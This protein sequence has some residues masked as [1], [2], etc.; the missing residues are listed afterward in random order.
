MQRAIRMPRIGWHLLLA[1]MLLVMQQA[2]LRH[3]LQHATQD[4]GHPAHSTLC[5]E[6]LAYAATDTVTPSAPQVIAP[7]AVHGLPP[8]DLRQAQ[9]DPSPQAGYQTRAPPRADAQ[10]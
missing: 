6:C 9:C 3:A 4:D 8:D 2:A 10:A 1:L 7:L 5:K